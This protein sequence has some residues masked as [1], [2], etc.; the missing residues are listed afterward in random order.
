MSGEQ[1]TY[2]HSLYDLT[3]FNTDGF[4]ISG[5]NI[6]IHDVNIWNQDDCI[7]VKSQDKSV[8]GQNV[9]KI[10]YLAE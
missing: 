1:I 6:Y 2:Y 5:K 9:L 4:D 3:A 8:T 10:C 7:A